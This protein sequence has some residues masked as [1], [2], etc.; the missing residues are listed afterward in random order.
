MQPDMGSSST[1][2]ARPSPLR[3]REIAMYDVFARSLLGAAL[4]SRQRGRLG[5][6]QVEGGTPWLSGQ[7][8][9]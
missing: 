2:A 7:F 6:V 8:S 9:T 3:C 5:T 1:P 4:H